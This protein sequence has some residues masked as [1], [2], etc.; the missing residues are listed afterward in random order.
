MKFKANAHLGKWE[1]LVEKLRD[2]VES[3]NHW[4]VDALIRP[5]SDDEYREMWDALYPE[6]ALRREIKASLKIAHNT[7]DPRYIGG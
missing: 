3:G 2:A 7:P 6:T 1:P 5:L 4:A